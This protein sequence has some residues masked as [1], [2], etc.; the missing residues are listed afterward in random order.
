MDVLFKTADNV[1]QKKSFKNNSNLF[2]MY[3][4]SQASWQYADG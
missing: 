2:T 3:S 4:I 1:C